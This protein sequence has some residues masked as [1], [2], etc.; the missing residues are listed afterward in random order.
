MQDP[1]Q[2]FER[3]SIVRAS[4]LE[5]DRGKPVQQTDWDKINEEFA[6]L[7]Q[8]GWNLL[9]IIERPDGLWEWLFL[10]PKQ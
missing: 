3:R 8:E 1:F 10:R 6:E 9:A 4:G 7:K 5:D 2:K